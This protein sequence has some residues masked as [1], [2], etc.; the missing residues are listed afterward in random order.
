MTLFTSYAYYR[1][2][3]LPYPPTWY[4]IPDLYIV[5]NILVKTGLQRPQIVREYNRRCTCRRDTGI[6]P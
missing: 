1:R 2:I 3:K 5:D 4:T 6:I